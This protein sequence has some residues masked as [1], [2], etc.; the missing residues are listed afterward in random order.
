MDAWTPEELDQL[1]RADTIRVA[2]RR[3]D[4]SSRT[5][6]IVWQV[7]VDGVL[8]LRSV[9]GPEGEW[10]KGVARHHE[11]F[12]SRGGNTRAVVFTRDEDHD[13]AIDAAYLEKYG[14]GPSTTAINT[15]LAK[16]TTLRVDPA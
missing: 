8:Y 6:V 2:G 7:V 10:Y 5:L 11:G 13:P 15:D 1:G 14:D 16:Q 9:K 4:G 3:M 12:I